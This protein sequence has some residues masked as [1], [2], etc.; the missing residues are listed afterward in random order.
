MGL[1]FCFCFL[2]F[3]FFIYFFFYFFLNSQLENLLLDKDG[4]IK[5]ADFGLCK[6]DITYGRTTKT[7]CGT[8]EYL[9]PEVLEDNDYGR[10]V[11]WWG[12]GVV[13]YELMCGRLPFYDRDHDVLFERILLEEVRFPRTLSQEAKDLLSGLL[14]KD[15]QKRLGGGPEDYKEITQHPFFLPISWTDLEQRKVISTS[16]VLGFCLNFLTNLLVHA[17][18]TSV[19]AAGGE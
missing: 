17:D 5:I 4:H 8:P 19:Q 16:L 12:L 6:E 2:F 18:S 1:C 15:P 11:D 10:A 13:M 3:L 14:A 7:F 9:A